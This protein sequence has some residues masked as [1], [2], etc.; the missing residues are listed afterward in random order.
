M[1][2]QVVRDKRISTLVSGPN[3]FNFMEIHLLDVGT[4][5]YGD[6]I[7][8]HNDKKRIL[9]DGAHRGDSV[10]LTKQMKAIFNEDGPF[11]FDLLVLTH[12][13]DDH[14]GCLPELIKNE[15]ITAS[16]CL[17]MDPDFRWK[18]GANDSI[19]SN[20]ALVDALLEEDYSFL[21]DSELGE[22]IDG[23][24]ALVDRYSDMIKKLK[25]DSDEVMLFK[26]VDAHDYKPL[27]NEF[28]SLGLKILG[29]TKKHLDLTRDALLDL[30]D[31]LTGVIKSSSF[32]DSASSDIDR[33]RR[34]YSDGITDSAFAIDAVKN[35]GSINNE[36]IVLTF[37]SEDENSWTAFLAGDMQ[38]AEPEV[39]GLEMEMEKLL[40]KVNKTKYD[41][42]KTSHHTSY[43]GLNEEM[44]DEW[45]GKG[46][47]FYGH[48][49]GLYDKSHPEPE[50]L[51]VLK[52]RADKITFA[53]TDRNGLIKV[54]NDENS[55]LSMWINKGEVNTFTKNRDKPRSNDAGLASEE[56]KSMAELKT[57]IFTQ[58]DGDHIQV[59][60]VIPKDRGVRIIIEV[61]GEKKN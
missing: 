52:R 5:Q 51:D 50:V 43:N 40:D 14:I 59:S 6:C 25:Q 54:A 8:V 18:Q 60:A 2:N 19:S 28:K 49:G 23:A 61:D 22:F 16:K 30:V 9:V 17:L 20:D 4:R 57:G 27:E 34:L 58:V 44:L 15:E 7:I 48:S 32:I 42:I 11:H 10:L 24:G 26:G 55:V 37:K 36:S 29:P 53:R 39:A 3:K 56:K 12:L 13:H 41:F 38:F 21:S 35:K 47:E 45:I 33:Y 31:T 1:T 46:T